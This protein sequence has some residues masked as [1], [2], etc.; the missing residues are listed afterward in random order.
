[1]ISSTFPRLRRVLVVLVLVMA[2]AW[3]ALSG[4]EAE[5]AAA[6][7]ADVGSVDSIIE[8]VYDVISG[9]AGA[10]RDWDRMRS[11][12]LSDARLIPSFPGP[13]GA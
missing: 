10:E 3:D 1:M 5:R 13:D 4:Q 8:A 9:P 2:P 6:D 7:P 11:L 12:F